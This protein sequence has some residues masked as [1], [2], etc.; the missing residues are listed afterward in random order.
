AGDDAVTDPRGFGSR[1]APY[2][3]RNVDLDR[4][5]FDLR[6]RGHKRRVAGP[7]C[8][9]VEQCRVEAS[10]VRVVN[11]VHDL[12]LDIRVEN[13]DLETQFGGISADSLVI[14]GQGHRAENLGLDL[15]AHI[16]ARTVDNQNL[17]H[18]VLL[19]LRSR[20]Y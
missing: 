7:E 17:R 2:R 3:V 1:A 6:E 16:H 8:R 15:A 18:P 19:A 9:R 11:F 10:V 20:R 13:L 4:W 12:A 5:E 14:L